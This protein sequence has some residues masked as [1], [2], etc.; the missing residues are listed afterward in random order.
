MANYKI[1]LTK[2]AQKNLKKLDSQI[3]KKLLV[4]IENLKNNPFPQG[5]KKL[6]TADG[7]RL[8]VGDY[9]IVYDVIEDLVLVKI[10]KVGH[11]KDIYRE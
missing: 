5:V 3:L 4:R 8:R 10:L 6:V 1:E 11:R 2:T 9:R 7:Y